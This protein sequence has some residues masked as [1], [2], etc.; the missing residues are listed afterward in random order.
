MYRRVEGIPLQT[1][2]G[3]QLLTDLLKNAARPQRKPMPDSQALRMEGENRDHPPED[4][5]LNSPLATPT[6]VAGGHSPGGCKW[7]Y[8]QKASGGRA[9]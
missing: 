4:A 5:L 9:P 1:D 2:A 8:P 6:A 3:G 7:L